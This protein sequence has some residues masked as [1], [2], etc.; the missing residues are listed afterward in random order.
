MKKPVPKSR[1]GVTRNSNSSIYRC[2]N[3]HRT[4]LVSRNRGQEG[5]Y[6]DDD[7]S[8]EEGERDD[9]FVMDDDDLAWADILTLMRSRIMTPVSIESTRGE[10]LYIPK[11]WDRYRGVGHYIHEGVELIYKKGWDVYTKLSGEPDTL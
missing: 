9:N 7:Q 1:D 11:G 8:E 5:V 3:S 6:T 10:G 4:V 2:I